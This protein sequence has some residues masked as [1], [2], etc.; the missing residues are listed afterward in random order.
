M[1]EKQRH[2]SYSTGD[3]VPVTFDIDGEEFTC[4]PS[5]TGAVLWNYEELL[6][7]TAGSPGKQAEA[8]FSFFEEIMDA[9]EYERFRKYVDDPERN[10]PAPLLGQIWLDLLE[11][12]AGRPTERSSGSPRGPRKTRASSTES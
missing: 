12:Y 5:L 7:S 1:T 2:K 3:P 8:I 9:S 4:K 11:Q 10:V 6:V